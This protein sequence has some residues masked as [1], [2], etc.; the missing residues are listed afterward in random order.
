VTQVGNRSRFNEIAYTP[1]FHPELSG[2]GGLVIS[3]SI[4]SLNGLNALKQNIHQYQPR[5]LLLG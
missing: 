2:T 4:N 1:T 5:W 3:Y